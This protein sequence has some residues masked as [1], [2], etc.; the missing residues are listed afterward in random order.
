MRTLIVLCVVMCH[1]IGAHAALHGE[2]TVSAWKD[3]AFRG[4]TIACD[5]AEQF[6]AYL[7]TFYDVFNDATASL[8]INRREGYDACLLVDVA[9]VRVNGT[10]RYVF[11]DYV[12]VRGVDR[13]VP[14]REKYFLVRN[15]R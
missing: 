12:I 15:R 6:E 5:T 11:D 7:K 9:T 14:D 8:L 2:K 13:F 4:N 3:F 10:V 1:T